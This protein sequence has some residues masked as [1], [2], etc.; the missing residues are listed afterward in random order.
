VAAFL[1]P[2]WFEALNDVL[3]AA[4]PVPLDS[5]HTIRVVLEFPDAPANGAHALTFTL[6]P[7]GASAE[8]GDHLAANALIQLS[9]ADALALTSGT[10]NSASAL[11]EGRIKVRGDVNAVV[12][13]LA[14]LQRAHPQGDV[15]A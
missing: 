7:Q 4:G 8:S 14:W 6:S 12:P 11:R 3:R 2:E 5:Q 1:G 13:L 15:S 10:L 9:Y